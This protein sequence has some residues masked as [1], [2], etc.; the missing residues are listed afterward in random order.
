MDPVERRAFLRRIVSTTSGAIAA[1][2]AG[3]GR[4]QESDDPPPTGSNDPV[5]VSDYGT[6]TLGGMQ[7][8]AD[9]SY[10]RGWKIQQHVYTKHCRLLNPQ[11]GRHFSGS[12][13]DCESALQQ[14][15]ASR[16]LEPDTG[17]AVILVHGIIRSS[18]SFGPM[19]DS[20]RRQHDTVVGFEYPSTRVPISESAEYLHLLMES[21]PD[22]DTIDLVVHSMGGLIVRSYL[23]RHRD[24]RLR[25]M[26][27]LGTPNRGAE[28]ADLF[29]SGLLYRWVL[30]PAGQ[31]LSTDAEGVI[32]SLPV[33]DFEFG[34][35]A[36]GTGGDGYNPLL[37]GDDDGTVTVNSAQLDGA[38]D[39]R[40]FPCLHT[41]LPRNKAV[42]ESTCAFL[43]HGHF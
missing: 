33:P 39:F 14:V 26:V 42:I 38:A 43:E 5:E 35:I 9:R 4:G 18:R 6:P 20:L 30:G 37:P 16:R 8:W 40:V 13:A 31:E 29:R 19:P 10:R 27:M 25:R 15:I 23:A 36:G 22:V 7:F 41:M 28:L 12:L 1:L 24:P 21:M 17:A 3:R 34:I 2:H 32:G 11:N